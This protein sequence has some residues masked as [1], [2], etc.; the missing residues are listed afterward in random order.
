MPVICTSVYIIYL[1]KY[2][3][4]LGLERINFEVRDSNSFGGV[5]DVRSGRDEPKR[6]GSS[7][8]SFFATGLC[9]G[10]CSSVWFGGSN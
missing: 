8:L 2:R 5:Q 6:L 9:S 4:G 7:N 10:I 1:K 3:T